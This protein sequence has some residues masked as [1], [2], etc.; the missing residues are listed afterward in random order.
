M[1]TEKIFQSIS[2]HSAKMP[3]SNEGEVKTL[4]DKGKLRINH[5]QTCSERI[6]KVH[7]SSRREMI[8]EGNLYHQE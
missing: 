1:L 7:F 8:P 3:F 4:P 6:A 2:L 5:W